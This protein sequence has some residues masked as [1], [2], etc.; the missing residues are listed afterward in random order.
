MASDTDPGRSRAAFYS[1]TATHIM[2]RAHKGFR[3]RQVDHRTTYLMLQ[4]A[5]I[6]MAEVKAIFAAGVVCDTILRAAT[7]RAHRKL[8]GVMKIVALLRRSNAEAV[9]KGMI[10]KRERLREFCRGASAHAVL[11]RNSLAVT[12]TMPGRTCNGDNAGD[13]E[14]R[15]VC[16]PDNPTTWERGRAVAPCAQKRR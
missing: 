3:S 1:C 2:S 16:L 12:E 13:T 6:V 15:V 5:A 8:R 9:R 7:E 11:V 4:R 10:G 14:I